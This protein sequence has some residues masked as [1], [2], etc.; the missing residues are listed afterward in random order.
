[1]RVIGPVELAR[2]VHPATRFCA[3]PTARETQKVSLAA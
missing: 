3:E 2:S 1:M